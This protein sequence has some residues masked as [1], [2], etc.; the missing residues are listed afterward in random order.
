MIL[1]ETCWA[2]MKD[3]LEGDI[4]QR[5]P[6]LTLPCAAEINPAPGGGDRDH[7][8]KPFKQ[9]VNQ[10]LSDS[11]DRGLCQDHRI[12]SLWSVTGAVK[13]VSHS[14]LSFVVPTQ[15]LQ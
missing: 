1:T 8:A 7:P 5:R 13:L 3:L 14:T 10:F 2:S 15:V 6:A 12:G 9:L 4:D 11:R